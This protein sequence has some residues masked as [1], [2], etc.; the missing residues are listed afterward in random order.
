MERRQF[1]ATAVTGTAL[2]PAGSLSAALAASRP[3]GNTT[4]G[5][6]DRRYL[7]DLLLQMAQPVLEPM[8]RGQLQRTFQPEVG[9]SWDGRDVAV[10]YLECFGRLMSGIAPWLALPDDAS[11]ES[12]QRAVLRGQVLASFAHAVD[13]HSPDYLRWHGHGQALVDAAFFSNAFLRAPGLWAAL[14]AT[15]QRRI[16]EEIKGLRA[17]APPYNN[18]LLFAAMNEAFLLSIGEKWDPI[19]VDLTL[20]KIREW[21]VGDGW[22]ADG[23]RFHYDYYGSYVIHPMLVEI[24][25]V[26]VAANAQ[27]NALRPAQLL[28][29]AIKRMQRYGEHLERMIGPDGSFPPIGRSLTYRTAVFQPLGLLAWRKRLPASLPEGQVRAATLAAQRA[30]FGYASNFDAR[31]YLTLGFTGHQPELADS[32]SN[33]GSMYLASQSLIALGLPAHDGYWTAPAQPWTMQKAFSG[34]NFP[35]DGYVN[36]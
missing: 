18:W 24:L 1:L 32:Y 13:P 4:T 11:A 17:I 28:E 2:L 36:D 8:S 20:R 22:Y 9:P 7:L 23:P 10:A 30:V 5:A 16:V 33:A 35:R 12:R 27:F 15:T 26:L 14:D 31:G 21:Y 6:E 3:A 25:D 34:A 19:R 29:E